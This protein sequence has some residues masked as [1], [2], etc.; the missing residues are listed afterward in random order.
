M[1]QNRRF[2]PQLWVFL[3]SFAL[4]A[5][6]WLPV[7]AAPPAGK[8]ITTSDLPILVN[9]NYARGGAT[10]LPGS[11]LETPD[12]AAAFIQLGIGDV[13]LPPASLATLNFTN[14]HIRVTLTR[15]CAILT[16]NPQTT[17]EIVNDKGVVLQTNSNA[18]EGLRGTPQHRMTP[19]VPAKTDGKMFRRLPVCD[20]RGEPAPPPAPK[21]SGAFLSALIALFGGPVIITGIVTAG[22][23]PS[24][25]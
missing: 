22:G 25:A 10:I 2:S 11:L 4:F 15:G 20:L 24:P 8:L 16:A 23:N 1:S 5:N 7:L 6:C 14:N 19:G 9:G 17:G 21:T 12:N 13:E 18:E 3:L